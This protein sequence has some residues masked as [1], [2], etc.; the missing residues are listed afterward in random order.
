MPRFQYLAYSK[1]GQQVAGQI[2][3]SNQ[4][5]ALK[6]ISDKGLRAFSAALEEPGKHPKQNTSYFRPAFMALPH[7]ATLARELATLIEAGLPLDE[8]L[9]IAGQQSARRATG[10]FLTGVRDM[11]TGGSSLSQAVSEVKPGF[12]ADEAAMILA[13][14]QTGSLAK[15]LTG[16]AATLEQRAEL[17]QQI[18]SALVYPTILVVMALAAI[19]IIGTVLVPNLLPIF[20]DTGAELPLVVSAMIAANGFFSK[21]WP[22]LVVAACAGCAL[23]I[24]ARRNRTLQLSFDRAKMRFPGISLMVKTSETARISGTLGALLE[25]GVPLIEALKI[26]AK[27]S[28]NSAI[29]SRLDKLTERV[30]AGEKISQALPDADFFPASGLQLISI[31][32]E[33]NRLGQMFAHVAKRSEDGLRTTVQRSMTLLTP[34]LTIAIGIFVGGLIMSV[35]RAILSVN[36]LAF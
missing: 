17:R 28:R 7:R 1:D 31:G 4:A 35:M 6:L 15:V 27:V 33:T 13:G 21:Y 23:I 3:A 14:E 36:E 32:E 18:T 19:V 10:V 11:V 9:R 20:E 22:I 5:H 29:A 2:E 16:L 34:V 30:V 24:L 8:T 26:V 12:P 25:S